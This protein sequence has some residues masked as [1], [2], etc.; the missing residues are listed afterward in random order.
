MKPSGISLLGYALLGLLSQ[1]PASGYD[2]RK[3]FTDTPM[4]TFSNSPGA[5]Y[6]ALRR[7]EAGKLIHGQVENASGLRRRKVFHLTA[8]GTSALKEWLNRPVS[9]EDVVHAADELMLRFSFMEQIIGEA[10]AIRFLQALEKE[11][12]GYVPTLRKY[13][14]SH[15]AGMPR[16]GSLALESGI[17]GYETLLGW[18]RHAIKTY[19]KKS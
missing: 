10:A 2:I 5:I 16:S 9:C 11:L 6:P 18:C 19:E 12:E 1:Q 3:I 13:L 7:L 17:R 15:Q 4:G 14:E 8:A